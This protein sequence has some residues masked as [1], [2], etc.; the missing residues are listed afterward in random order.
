M[1]YVVEWAGVVNG[2]SECGRL[3]GGDRGWR[4]RMGMAKQTVLRMR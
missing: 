2:C 4:E 1:R 3:L